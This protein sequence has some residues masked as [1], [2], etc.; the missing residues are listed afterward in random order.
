MS[1]VVLCGASSYEEKYY[2]NPEFDRLP[3]SI[4][5]ELKIM[6][7]LYTHEIGGIL[8]LVYEEDGELNFE[9]SATEGDPMF[10]EIGSRLK[11]KELQRTKEELLAA[12]QMYY[13]VVFLREEV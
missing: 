12:L 11:I 6:C 4:K 2:L 1:K 3:N 5:D 13:R 9:V 7:V 8:T 10:D